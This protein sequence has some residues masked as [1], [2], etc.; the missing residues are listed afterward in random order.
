MDSKNLAIGVLT[1]TATILFVGLVIV[2]SIDAPP[3]YG[4][5]QAMQGGDYLVVT[6]QQRSERELLYVIDA[7]GR[8]ERLAA[9]VFDRDRGQ[10]VMAS[11]PIDLN[12]LRPPRIRR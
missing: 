12:R 7:G 8:T 9:Y 11:P 3:A 6:G 10:L 4:F 1:V 5:G 2:N